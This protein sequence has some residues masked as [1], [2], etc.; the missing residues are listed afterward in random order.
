LDVSTLLNLNIVPLT[1]VGIFCC[2]L[3]GTIIG[4]E[5][6]LM[7]KPV[8]IRTSSLICLGTYT[9]IVISNS[10]LNEHGD[11]SRVIGQVVTGIGFLGAGVMLSRDG[12]VM[13][14]T[15]AAAIWILAAVGVV[16]GS[17]HNISGVKLAILA[18]VIL[19]GVNI[20]ESSFKT[21][22]RGVHKRIINR[23]RKSDGSPTQPNRLDS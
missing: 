9:F 20:L 22:Q 7:G 21:L 10:V 13:G 6:Q 16:I 5:R 15:S 18:V 4:L 3:S 2:I 23:N 1:W 19:V 11:A 8:G 12:V 14:V 17:G